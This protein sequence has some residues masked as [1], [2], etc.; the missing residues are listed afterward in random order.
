MG[1]WQ[2]KQVKTDEST[3]A[4]KFVVMNLHICVIL[5]IRAD[6]ILS[7]VHA[8]SLVKKLQQ[9]EHKVCQSD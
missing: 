5:P 1:N 7:S 8:Y 9:L 6:L 3:C 2:L 4:W